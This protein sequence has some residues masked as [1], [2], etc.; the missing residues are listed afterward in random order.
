VFFVLVPFQLHVTIRVVSVA[1]LESAFLSTDTATRTQYKNN[2]KVR[3]FNELRSTITHQP[4]I[5]T[6]HCYRSFLFFFFNSIF[7]PSIS[8]IIAEYPH[9]D[10]LGVEMIFQLLVV[11]SDIK[12][13][14][15][16]I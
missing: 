6:T 7:R 2:K 1:G 14:N 3:E 15:A 4:A 16:L 11:I 9:S 8:S 13:F 12:L 5:G 10:L